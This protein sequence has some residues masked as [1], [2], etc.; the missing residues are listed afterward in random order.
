MHVLS[1]S[2]AFLVNAEVDSM[3]GVIDGG[4]GVDSKT[5][6]RASIEKARAELR[7]EFDVREERRRELEFLEKGGNP[8]DFKLGPATSISVQSTSATDQHTE[9]EAKDSFALTPSPHGD[10][11]DSSVRPPG[12]EPTTADNLLLFDGGKD[13]LHGDGNA[14]YPSRRG[15]IASSEEF[16]Q[17]GRSHKGKESEDTAMFPVG[18]RSQAYA[19]RNRSR[20]SRDSAHACSTNLVPS[21]H[22]NRSSI[23]PSSC[24][25]SRNVKGSL[26]ETH[27]DE[28]HINSS[29]CNSKTASPNANVV[30]K[31]T[32]SNNKMDMELGAEQGSEAVEQKKAGLSGVA[33]IKEGRHNQLSQMAVEQDH[34]ALSTR[35]VGEGEQELEGCMPCVAPE[36]EGN[37]ITAGQLNGISSNVEENDLKNEGQNTRNC[38]SA[39]VATEG[40]DSDL[41]CKKISHSLDENIA[42]NEFLISKKVNGS[43]NENAKEQKTVFEVTPPMPDPDFVEETESRCV[44]VQA[45]ASDS[46]PS[47]R[48]NTSV[49]DAEVKIEEI[50]YGRSD[51]QNEA[52]PVT[53]VVGAQ[54]IQLG[55][56][57]N[58]KKTSVCSEARLPCT[59]VS[60]NSERL[61]VISPVKG[62][63]AAATTELQSGTGNHLQ[64]AKEHEDAILERARTIEASS[65]RISQLSLGDSHSVKRRKCHWDFVLEEMAWL[66]N[67]FM[68]ERI[69]KITAAA[70]V[71]HCAAFT[72]RTKF[73]VE[74]LHGKQKEVA[75]TLAQ[76]IMQFWHS[77]EVLQDRENPSSEL[78]DHSSAL[79]VFGKA[80]GVES[81]KDTEEPI[82][83]QE[84][85]KDIDGNKSKQ[86]LRLP[87]QRYALR[88][89]R[90]RK[91]SDCS[92]QA[93]AAMTPDR[94]SNALI[95]QLACEDQY[96]EKNLF[97]AV[98]FGAMEEYR[99][100]V[101]SHWAQN[102]RTGNTMFQDEVET[103]LFDSVAE[104]GSRENVDEED[105]VEAGIYYLPRAFE[106][107]NP[108]KYVQRT[109]KSGQK[110]NGA[111]SF[112]LGS[113]LPYGHCQESKPGSHSLLLSVKR[114][115]SNL[116]LGSIPTKRVR[117]AKR[118]RAVSPFG[119]GVAGGGQLESKTEASSGDTTSFYEDQTSVHGGSQTRKISEVE[120]TGDFAKQLPFDTTGKS[121]KPKKKKAK[122]L[123]FR[124]T[125][126][127]NDSAGFMG[128][129]KGS[130]TFEQ[131]W[132]LDSMAQH[133]QN[134]N[135]RK[136]LESHQ[137]ESNGNTGM[138]G[139]PG[140]KKPRASK[141]L[142]NA[143]LETMTPMSGSIPSPVAS[144]MSNMSNSNKLIKVIA[145]RDRDRKAKA[146]KMSAGQSAFG[147]PWSDYEDQALV[148][149]V[150]D[151]GPNWEL[152]SDAL[153][154]SLQ[155]KRI[156]RKPKEC[157]E[158]HKELMDSNAGD[159]AD[160]AE[161]SGSSQHYH[162]TLPGI[163][164]ACARQL[165]QHL[166]GPME[167]DTLKDHFEKIIRLGQQLHSR[168]SQCAY[169]YIWH[170]VKNDIQEV[171]QFTTAHS[172]HTLA[173]SDVCPNNSNGGFL[174]PLDLCE[175]ST[176]SPDVL[177][178]GRQGLHF[179]GLAVTNHQG[180]AAPVLPASGTNPLLQVSSG[181]VLGNG[182]PSP[183]AT[184]NG[185]VRDMQR[186]SMSR[187]SPLPVD[188]QQRMQ[189]SSQMLPSRNIKH[190]SVAVSG[191]LPTGNDHGVHMPSGANGL[192]MMC[193]MKRGMAMPRPAF[194]GIVSP[195]MINMV[196]PANGVGM[197][198]PV[199]I[200]NGS[201]S[202]QGNPI[203]RP[204]EALQ[205]LR[206]GQSPEDQ[207]QKTQELQMQV[208]H[209]NGPGN[210]SYNGS[211]TAFPNQTGPPV[212]HQQQQQMPHQS[213]V[214]SNV[215]QPRLQGTNTSTHQQ[216]Y[217]I[218]VPKQRHQLQQQRLLQQ[219]QQ[220]TAPNSSPPQHPISAVPNNNSQI[221]QSS[222]Q[223]VPVP[224]PPVNLQHPLTTS[225]VNTATLQAQQKQHHVPHGLSRSPQT[226]GAVP[227]QMLKQRQ[228]QQLQ[229]PRPRPQ[230][231][232][233]SQQQGKFM[234]GIGKGSMML[235]QNLP[236]DAPQVNGLS[237][238][239]IHVPEKGEQ[240][241][242]HLMQ[243]Q[244]LFPGSGRNPVPP[245]K[246]LEPQTSN[247]VQQQK[248]LSRPLQPSQ[249]QQSRTLPHLDNNNQGQMQIPPSHAFSASQ[250]PV[251]TSPLAMASQQQQQ[252]HRQT[253][254][255]QQAVQRAV[256]KNCQ[257]CSDA[258]M[259][260]LGDQ[261]EANSQL[262]KSTLQTGACTIP[263]CTA[264]N[265][266]P[267]VSSVASSSHLKEPLY[268]T[269]TVSPI[270]HLSSVG[271]PHQS[272]S[273]GTEPMS[274]SSQRLVNQGQFSGSI[275]I[276]G[277]IGGQRQQQQLHQLPQ[278]QPQQQLQ[279]QM[280]CGSLHAQCTVSGPV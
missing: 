11:V 261:A 109:K 83:S 240:P 175:A 60:F 73:S 203:M 247:Q 218:R 259:Q 221:Q 193:G 87:I 207:R 211:S 166:Q 200:H 7:Q 150:H 169:E 126:S 151:M 222:T 257:T 266:V 239:G 186:Y 24:H 120:S 250:Q 43:S 253:S 223:S 137:L 219:Q 244:G 185:P 39:P 113:D 106:G 268:E 93:Q 129:V 267:G 140:A 136:R 156:F 78:R 76:A 58:S 204:R 20:S 145:G 121:T 159:G 188:E 75:Y 70:H 212:Q 91:S 69:W 265:N 258:P 210:V 147:N 234:K 279:G 14:T 56:A 206:P 277:Q 163:P 48:K 115:S 111:R 19:R 171:K 209:R 149:L 74:T 66:S 88:F 84:T 32:V 254:Q 276:H 99:N 105:E 9:H 59:S 123:G 245:T 101:S 4:A 107:T 158:R 3:G 82:V 154:S 176:S 278:Q 128:S 273:D 217:V 146:I 194:Q 127:S 77:F 148:V 61:E 100:S 227:N 110:P 180:S 238:S 229:Q 237:P 86:N 81:V 5:S 134:D 2:S 30:S 230:Q 138:Y 197:A 275:Q 255:Q 256:Q 252:P 184:L 6:C 135:L 153:N 226:G 21:S 246:Q 72:G 216:T 67:D 272:N 133:E 208:T 173:L 236:I 264:L 187:P 47:V 53:S 263:Q 179:S 68:Q 157:K 132:Q 116:H 241:V 26:C 57:N 235:N 269:N 1:S 92:V 165:L 231:R 103:S 29:I 17:P 64:L 142:P 143:S 168:R 196:P 215:H 40:L 167:E 251:L 54:L 98:P 260:S 242:M 183:S 8:L 41:S 177:S 182:L 192:G 31:T 224:L 85:S 44:D 97:Y 155:F 13:M 16:S 62:S 90:Y 141:Q 249:K 51:L 52:E 80:N 189:H 271:N 161:D 139:H 181:M 22:S 202:G 220:F 35:S 42:S 274:S 195:S 248:M 63:S 213:H 96:S 164:K 233:Q 34:K 214:L 190:S 280:Q 37:F 38:F 199:N 191:A 10:S 262:M 102:E 205:M 118:Q 198:S 71:S 50:C 114:P 117:T 28:G 144:Q 131:R 125:L 65:K 119:V 162:S 225:S 112:E 124:N 33:E 160:S 46:L 79:L 15:H 170:S 23:L 55:D 172:S 18:V 201:V 36:N 49:S 27:L 45:T 12:R 243:G 174:T 94:K 89:L 178:P 25:N 130:G 108:S 270:I 95:S 228:L 122:H 104:F 152:V 232:Q